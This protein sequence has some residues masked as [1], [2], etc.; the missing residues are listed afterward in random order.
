MLRF[1]AEEDDA[2]ISMS[3][4]GTPLSISLVYVKDGVE[5]E[6]IPGTTTVTLDHVGDSVII[7][8]GEDGNSTINNGTASYYSFVITNK[9]AASGSIMSLLDST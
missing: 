1:T 4:T 2:T 5:N 8:A 6:F 7:K 3:K 9:V